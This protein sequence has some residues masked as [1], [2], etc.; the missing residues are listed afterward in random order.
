MIYF[1]F[2]I[3]NHFLQ[4]EN[5]K[6]FFSLNT[7]FCVQNKAPQD[8]HAPSKFHCS[9]KHQKILATKPTHVLKNSIL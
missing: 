2:C 3:R 4:I 9:Q 6:S 5:I 1:Y 7:K 8:L